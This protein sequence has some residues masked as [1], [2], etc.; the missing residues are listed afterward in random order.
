MPIKLSEQ[1]W[2]S[3][4]S[5]RG[6]VAV[7][8]DRGLVL[9]VTALSPKS[10]EIWVDFDASGNRPSSFS[11][12]R[13][14]APSALTITEKD[15]YLLLSAGEL[16]LRIYKEQMR[17]VFVDADDERIVCQSREIERSEDG[18][19]IFSH[20]VAENE[21]FYGL[22]EDNAV[23]LG[24]LDRRGHR[25]EMITGQQINIGKVT[26]DIPV[27]FYLS[28]G[29][30]APYGIF[31][32]NSYPMVYDMGKTD[33]NLCTQ[34]AAGG[35]LV[36]YFFSGDTFG[37]IL[38]EYTDLTGKPPMPP[39]WTQGYVQCR[40]SYWNWEQVDELIATLRDKRIPLDCIVFDYDWAEYFNNYRWNPRWQGKSPEKI[41]AYRKEGL[42]FMV[43]NSGPMLKKDSDTYESAL[44]AGVLARDTE[45]DP[46][47]CGHFGGDLIDFSHPATKEWLRPQLTRLLDEGVESWWLDLTEPEGDPENTVYYGGSRAAIHNV[48]SLLNTKTYTEITREHMPSMRPFVLTRTGTAGIQKYCTAIWS[49]DVYSDYKTFSAHIPEALNTGLSGIPLWTC[50]AG[51]F[52]SASCNARDDRHLYRNDI[53][54]HANLYERWVQFAC[55]SP[56]M[57]V[58]HA[59]E[60]APYAF[61]ELFTDSIA[62][63][64]RLRYRLLPYIYSYAYQT[65]QTGE[66]L[67]RPLVYHYPHDE[68]VYD[69]FDEY[70]FGRELLVAPVHEEEQ[71]RREV[72]LP[73][74]RWYDFDY[75]YAY[76]GG[77]SYEVYAPQN[78][79]PV[80]VRAGAIIPMSEQIYNSSELDRETVSAVVYP[81]GKSSFTHYADDGMTTDCENGLFTLTELSCEEELGVR[82]RI[83]CLRSNDHF[84]ARTLRLA[85]HVNAVPKSVT[86]NGSAATRRGHLCEIEEETSGWYYNEFSRL[87]S[88]KASVSDAENTVEIVYEADSLISPPAKEGGEHIADGRSPYILPAPCLPCR[89]GFEQFDRGG[90]GV[91]YHKHIPD[92]AD[93]I[94]RGES[95]GI[96]PCSDIGA[97]MAVSNLC[98]GEWL[99]Y[100]VNVPHDGAYRFRLRIA[101]TDHSSV[102]VRMGERVLID[103]LDVSGAQWHDV[104][105][106]AVTLCRGIQTIRFTVNAGRLSGNYFELAE[107]LA[108]VHSQA[109]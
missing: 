60:S 54:R 79:I 37:E 101:G 107:Q 89:I 102:S 72:Y 56:I 81:W 105:S 2:K 100:T 93:G 78:R 63:Y 91:A 7:A 45:G 65:H 57:R 34:E 1:K 23:Y 106:E 9:R 76:E 103:E 39:I 86:V 84:A 61:G 87:L 66:P 13:L 80:F 53:A 40:C 71:C 17:L 29:S 24:T 6:S 32:D 19:V 41:A 52:I 21:H 98:A 12:E 64:I 31:T 47:T 22:G 16:A 90:E 44:Q 69:L 28:T 11:I 38:N 94:Y 75:G 48:F 43:S 15:T 99:E 77:R 67:I 25:R 88:V 70:L 83:G 10:M 8:T 3:T 55:F 58:H 4:H 92:N 95:V 68:K 82:T 85:I 50:D 20:Y 51:G 18:R 30:T 5:E 35:D 42:H 36:F 73:E 96:L 97:G 59:G 62:H 26:A 109:E 74:G 14:P 27:T 33:P 108:E 46:I 104:C 49:G